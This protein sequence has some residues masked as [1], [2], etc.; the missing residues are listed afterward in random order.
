[1]H[2]ILKQYLINFPAAHIYPIPITQF[3]ILTLPTRP[4]IERLR[5]QSPDQNLIYRIIVRSSHLID[6][7]TLRGERCYT[8]LALFIAYRPQTLLE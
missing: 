8:L 4:I 7:I 3:R 6:R 5:E 1:M 2:L